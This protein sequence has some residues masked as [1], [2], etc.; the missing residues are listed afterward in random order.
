MSYIT[1]GQ[2]NE[3]VDGKLPLVKADLSILEER[4]MYG[5]TDK[6]PYGVLYGEKPIFYRK[7][8]KANDP[9]WDFDGLVIENQYE[10]DNDYVDVHDVSLIYNRVT[11]IS[12]EKDVYISSACGDNINVFGEITIET[13]E[14]K[15]GEE[16]KVIDTVTVKGSL[17]L[18]IDKD[19]TW[20]S[21]LN[22]DVNSRTLVVET[23]GSTT[24]RRTNI[25]AVYYYRNQKAETEFTLRQEGNSMSDW[26]EDGR[27]IYSITLDLDKNFTSNSGDYVKMTVY[28][29]YAIEYH[30]EDMCGNIIAQKYVSGN[31]SDITSLCAF[32]LSNT[33]GF[34]R[35][36]SGI[37]VDK[38]MPDSSE[39]KTTITATY[40]GFID[41][42]V[43]KQESGN[44]V[45]ER[46]ELYFN[47]NTSASLTTYLDN[48]KA[49]T[50]SIPFTAKIV[51][52]ANG[53]DLSEEQITSLSA[54]TECEWINVYVSTKESKLVIDVD[55]NKSLEEERIGYVSLKENI[56]DKEIF[57]TINQ[58]RN[59]IES[60]EYSIE[61]KGQSFY[62]IH[63]MDNAKLIV[64]PIT[65][66]NYTDGGKTTQDGLVGNVSLMVSGYSTDRTVIKLGKL[67][68]EDEYYIYTPIIVGGTS[69]SNTDLAS[70]FVVVDEEGKELSERVTKIIT[71]EGR[72]E[73]TYSYDF[74][75]S[76]NNVSKTLIWSKNNL[77]KNRN[78][79]VVSK[80]S[81]YKN[82]ILQVTEPQ[83][84]KYFG[85]DDA[86]SF[87][88]VSYGNNIINFV[89]SVDS[90]EETI[91]K[92]FVVFQNFTQEQLIINLMLST[93]GDVK[94]IDFNVV[95]KQETPFIDIWTN[96][97]AYVNVKNLRTEDVIK[98]NLSKGWMGSSEESNSDTLCST[99]LPFIVGDTY[100]FKTVG[101]QILKNGSEL[102]GE[103]YNILETKEIDD[104]VD[105]VKLIINV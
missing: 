13:V 10:N 40:C 43:L 45:S 37:V 33:K 39:R 63:E 27:R 71:I 98:V 16:E 23:N 4:K 61:V 53:E 9:R 55:K 65:T 57:L 36:N 20:V 86:A 84:F 18:L 88:D 97:G 60:M 12:V 99:T 80:K 25:K 70:Y 59:E 14:R 15:Y 81:T 19:V 56:S 100:E 32:S 96:D 41:K 82:G 68:K 11:S 6:L 5:D 50:F 78:V 103:D 105:C 62:E 79:E 42:K 90:F 7:H 46:T 52:F 104:T 101:L 8:A 29:N 66:I 30:Q 94:D 72:T 77:T 74:T 34:K 22:D 51:R 83:S 21:K 67:E 91:M 31:S 28:K 26:I 47:E 24:P 17:L 75:F 87:F 49:Q 93:Q 64:K 102:I 92:K 85:L 73:I 44:K 54:S 89:P 48:A 3:L 38:Q 1:L 76:D 35:V 69:L 2:L 95:L 58:A